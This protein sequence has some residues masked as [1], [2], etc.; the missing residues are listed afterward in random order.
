[1]TTKTDVVRQVAEMKCPNCSGYGYFQG[2]PADDPATKSRGPKGCLD[3]QG[4]GLK[5]PTLSRECRTPDGVLDC[6]NFSLDHVHGRIPDVSLEKVLELLVRVD[7]AAC[8]EVG[9]AGVSKRYWIGR[10]PRGVHETADTMLEAACRALLATE[11]RC[12]S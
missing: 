4:T 9:Y 8:W 5:Y 2:S 6:L 11:E 10:Q 1:M 12:P 3:C 7:H